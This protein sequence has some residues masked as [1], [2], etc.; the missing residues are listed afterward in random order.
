MK[1]GNI[2]VLCI[3]IFCAVAY[4]R[5]IPKRA[6]NPAGLTVLVGCDADQIRE[7]LVR[8]R[9]V[10]GLVLES[11]DVSP[12]RTKCLDMGIADRC[13]VDM[14][15]GGRLPHADNLVNRLVVAEGVRVTLSEI[16]RVLAPYGKLIIR[17]RGKAAE[18]YAAAKLKAMGLAGIAVDQQATRAVKPLPADM[19]EWTHYLHGADGNPVAQDDVVQ[20]PR[21]LRWVNSPKWARHHEHMASTSAMVS[22]GGRVFV[23]FDDG[24]RRSMLLPPRWKLSAYDAFNG[25]KLWEQ[26]IDQWF[27]H[28]YSFKAGPASLPRRLVAD[29]RFVYVTM[30]IDAPVSVLDAVS[31]KVLKVIDGTENTREIVLAGG[32]L[33]LSTGD[34][35]I[36]VDPAVGKILWKETCLVTT[37]TLAADKDRVVFLNGGAAVA[38]D[39]KD[40]SQLWPSRS[41]SRREGTWISK[42]PPRLILT[43][44]AVVVGSGKSMCALSVED[45]KALW[46]ASYS[47]SGFMSPKDLFVIDGL[48]WAGETAKTYS[49]G[50]MDGR[51]LL[52]GKVERSFLPDKKD[53]VWLSHHRCHFSKA[54]KNF[55]LTGRMGVEF[56]DIR[57]ETWQENHWI[58][59]GCIYGVMPCNGLLYLPP[60]PC[61]CYFEAKMNGLSA[62]TAD[63]GGEDSRI[64]EDQRLEKGS[65][66]AKTAA[67]KPAYENTVNHSTDWPVFRHDSARSGSTSSSVAGDLKEEWTVSI[68]GD[69]TQPVM[70]AGQLYVASISKH[71][72]YCLDL[73]Q[74]NRG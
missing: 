62:Y 66:F 26:P 40:G 42:G 35:L 21:Q 37:M 64:P 34:S 65:A 11:K 47:L 49:S 44:K 7:E 59:G 56:V 58:R 46:R 22:S 29:D 72:I 12:L 54:T 48:V 3:A 27:D 36:S 73:K 63:T 51:N 4:G 60:H 13:L 14:L 6:G 32:R 67:D 1:I 45:G 38:L 9:F 39:P 8:S 55:I 16:E 43:E 53:I 52:S 24:S 69:L 28:L 23:L 17:H 57:K 15:D 61:A 18:E 25:L 20:S 74:A 5:E 30:G 70:A 71:T 41:L 31:G 68:G 10:H 19:D 50:K 33:Y 2:I